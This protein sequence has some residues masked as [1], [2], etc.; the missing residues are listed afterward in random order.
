M[1]GALHG[2][3]MPRLLSL[4]PLVWVGTISYS[5]YLV[6]WPIVLMLKD[7]P[8]GVRL[9]VS[10]AAGVVMHLAVERPTRRALT[11]RSTRQVLLFWVASA[12]AATVL[13][14]VMNTAIG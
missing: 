12:S 4:Q 10:I 7:R 6:H 3:W 14:G 9:A 2:R 8:L 1:L 5:L 13:A 11:S